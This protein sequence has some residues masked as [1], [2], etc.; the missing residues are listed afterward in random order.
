MPGRRLGIT[1]T[2][3][4]SRCIGAQPATAT[5]GSTDQIW[6]LYFVSDQYS[7]G[8]RFRAI[9][10]FDISRENAWL[11]IVTGRS[12]EGDGVMHVLQHIK[13]QL[14]IAPYYFLR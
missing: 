6:S 5:V 10:A 9:T 13:Q 12:L 2:S 7:M 4:G 1:T 11:L 14:R 3:Q 8:G